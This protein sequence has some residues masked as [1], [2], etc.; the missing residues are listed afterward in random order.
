MTNKGLSWVNEPQ[1]ITPGTHEFDNIE[2]YINLGEIGLFLED[3]A[4]HGLDHHKA[5]N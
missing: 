4:D 5:V 3:N 1:W 2:T